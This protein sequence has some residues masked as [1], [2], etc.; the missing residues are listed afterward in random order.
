MWILAGSVISLKQI[1]QLSLFWRKPVYKTYLHKLKVSSESQQ[2]LTNFEF[3]F[4]NEQY[5]RIDDDHRNTRV[6]ITFVK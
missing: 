2:E 4:D 5:A 6:Q 3:I 1:Q